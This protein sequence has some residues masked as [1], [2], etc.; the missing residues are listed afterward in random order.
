MIKDVREMREKSQSFQFI[1]V[2]GTSVEFAE[3][4]AIAKPYDKDLGKYPKSVFVS[5]VCGRGPVGSTNSS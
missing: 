1:R 3:W 4:Y 2:P 5:A